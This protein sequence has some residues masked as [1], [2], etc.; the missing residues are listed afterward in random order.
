MSNLILDKL[1]SEL[2]I[3]QALILQEMPTRM[4]S[5]QTRQINNGLTNVW[6]DV[7]SRL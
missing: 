6:G 4:E 7:P 5:N 2:D 1:R 3:D